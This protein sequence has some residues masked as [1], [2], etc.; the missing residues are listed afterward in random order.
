VFFTTTGYIS[1]NTLKYQF[2]K[3][4]LPLPRF[5]DLALSSDVSQFPP[6][7]DQAAFA[8]ATDAGNEEVF[9]TAPSAFIQAETLALL[10]QNPAFIELAQFPTWRGKHYYLFAKRERAGPTRSASPSRD[11]EIEFPAPRALYAELNVRF[12]LSKEQVPLTLDAEIAH[13]GAHRQTYTKEGEQEFKFRYAIKQHLVATVPVK[14]HLTK[15]LEPFT[16]ATL[17]PVPDP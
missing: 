15:A 13:E 17:N 14:F 4:R 7:I 16:S 3:K 5:Y 1:A 10:R 8:I 9:Y 2:L 12:F 6:A 11:F